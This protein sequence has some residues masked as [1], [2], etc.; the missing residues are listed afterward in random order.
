[1]VIDNETFTDFSPEFISSLNTL[2]TII[3]K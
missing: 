1:V 3:G 2:I